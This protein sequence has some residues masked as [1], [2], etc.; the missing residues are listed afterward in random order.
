MN[1]YP[2]MKRLIQYILAGML[3]IGC[4]S[5]GGSDKNQEAADDQRTE[6]VRVME[7]AYADVAR[8]ATYTANL[9]AYREV[10]LVPA[11]PGRISKIFVEPGNRVTEGQVVV[12]MDQTQLHQALVQMS[13]IET[14]YRRIDTLRRVGS[15]S[16][17]QYD[18]ISTQFDLIR[19]N[20]AFL[21]E[22]T[23]LVA[24]FSGKVSGKYFENGEMFSGAPN[25]AAGKA[26]ILSI[27][28]TNRLKA[29]VNVAERFYPN[30]KQG[31]TVKIQSDLYSDQVFP[32][33]VSAI[34]P[35]IDPATRTFKIE[36]TVPNQ[37][38]MLIPGMFA[39]A[40][41]EFDQVQ[42][43][44]VPSLAIMKLQG[45]NERFVF[46]EQDGRAKRVVVELGDRYDEM[47]ELISDEISTGD[48]LI[49]A[50]QSR[51]LDGTPVSV[52]R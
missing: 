14:D 8:S 25:T 7:V 31:M 42:A 46:L 37:Q 34:Y 47:V 18:Q 27:V 40:I 20:V 51:L 12:E 41:L 52:I 44:V 16:Q 39:R 35:V 13:S 24:P 17:Q 30:V 22:N 45:S 11:T 43:I 10:H 4:S 50:G 26:A 6:P 28:Q 9:Q 33:T 1:T 23:R 2:T 38:D 19:S 32:G 5:S 3:F 29:L 15:V 49:I 36:I 21:K 48:K